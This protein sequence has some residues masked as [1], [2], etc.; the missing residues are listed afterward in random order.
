MSVETVG[1]VPKVSEGTV[2]GGTAWYC[3]EPSP[4]T[5]TDNEAGREATHG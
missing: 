4:Q 1:T 2:H 3:R 5:P